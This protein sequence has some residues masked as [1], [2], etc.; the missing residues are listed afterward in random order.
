MNGLNDNETPPMVDVNR[1]PSRWEREASA[2]SAAEASALPAMASSFQ[3][4]RML[5]I[6][7]YRSPGMIM[8][9]SLF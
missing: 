2:V 1:A 7:A 5:P 4:V 9:T 6:S 8:S 3:R